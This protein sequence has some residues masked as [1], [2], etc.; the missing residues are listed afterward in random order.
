MY[1]GSLVTGTRC[2]LI[3]PGY[4]KWGI[5]YVEYSGS[6]QTNPNGWP[7]RRILKTGG[8]NLI[9]IYGKFIPILVEMRGTY[10]HRNPEL[11]IF[12]RTGKLQLPIRALKVTKLDPT[13]D[14]TK[15]YCPEFFAWREFIF[16]V[17]VDEDTTE[18]IRKWYLT[19]HQ[20]RIEKDRADCVLQWR[21]TVK[22][23]NVSWLTPWVKVSLIQQT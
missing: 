10:E 15:R 20:Y 19:M 9:Q 17:Y 16:L 4:T 14:G 11:W 18:D 1:P 22:F 13:E 2:R 23:S 7:A 21:K 3:Y 12:D 6:R 5:P 8:W